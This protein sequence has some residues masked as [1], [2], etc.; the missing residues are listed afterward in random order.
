MSMEIKPLTNLPDA[1]RAREILER[2]KREFLPIA[3]ARGYTVTS[4]SEMCC[5][6]DAGRR[7]NGRGGGRGGRLMSNNVWGYNQ[8][9]GRNGTCRISIRLRQPTG[10]GTILPYE[11][12]AGTMAHELAHCVHGNHSA[13][14]YKLMDEIADQHA[15]YV[16]RGLV[17]D[18]GGFPMGG[19]SHTLGGRGQGA[20]RNPASNGGGN[21]MG[22]GGGNLR[23]AVRKAAEERSKRPAPMKPQKLGTGNVSGGGM[24]GGID[25]KLPPRE[26][27]RLAAERRA[28]LD[29]KWCLPCNEVIEI[30]SD[31]EGEENSG[32]GSGSD[33]DNDAEKKVAASAK[34]K[35]TKATN[36]D[37]DDDDDDDDI[38]I[39][40]LT[41]S[42][43]KKKSADGNRKRATASDGTADVPIDLTESPDRPPRKKTSSSV[44]CTSAATAST[45]AAATATYRPRSTEWACTACTL[46]NQSEALACDACGKARWNNGDE[47]AAAADAA[48]Q[49]DEAI[50]AARQNEIRQSE[51]TFGGFNIYGTK[52]RET[53]TLPHLT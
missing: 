36:D 49:R 21:S 47:A 44:T 27:A 25:P 3:R 1:E 50:A 16:A 41:A 20:V 2:L 37:D 29:S 6:G 18:R 46:Q 48:M 7:G 30:L 8:S 35:S 24:G 32:S 38:D 52:K 40:D 53:G 43:E 51:D 26:A 34:N 39:T 45:S 10:H 28:L 31:E 42:V 11:N 33:A 17:V 14:F 5:C 9:S 12:A 19:E 15:D 13:A 22:G 23:D 4:L